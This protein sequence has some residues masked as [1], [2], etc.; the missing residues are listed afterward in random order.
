MKMTAVTAVPVNVPLAS[1]YLNYRGAMHGFPCVIVRIDT[2]TGLSGY[3]ECVTLSMAGDVRPIARRILAAAAEVL[4]G[5]DPFDVEALNLEVLAAVGGDLDTLGG[6]DLALW[7]LMGKS[8]GVPVFRLMGGLCND[9]IAV[10]FTLGAQAPDLMAAAAHDMVGAGYHGLVVKVIGDLAEDVAR[11]AAVRSRVGKDIVLRVDC[12][13]GYDVATAL[14]FIEAIRPLDIEFIEQP[15]AARDLAGMRKCRE[16]GI[17][18]CADESLNSLQD[19]INLVS[20]SA[21]DLF[22]IKLPKVGGLTQAK[23]IAAIAA[24]AR[25]PLVVGGRTTLE[26]SRYAS[27]H[28][29]AS[30]PGTRGRAHEGPGPASQALSDDVVAVRSTREVVKWHGGCYPVETTPGLGAEVIWDKVEQYRIAW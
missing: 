22:N 12:N 13:T 8:L 15:V 11:V 24:A 17:A 6:V 19:A 7:D 3:G 29:A 2:D 4:V 23:K 30:T 5:R 28:F 26:L 10:D 14:R 21:C 20:E 18:V 1:P 9:P 25:I 27:R 16:A